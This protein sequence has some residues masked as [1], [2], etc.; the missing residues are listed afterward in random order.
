VLDV[1]LRIAREGAPVPK[2]EAT[3]RLSATA[4]ARPAILVVLLLAGCGG[5]TT[6]TH[7]TGAVSAGQRV[8]PLCPP[9]ARQAMA[10]FL[11]VPASSI[12]PATSTGNNAMPQCTFKASGVAKRPI[13]LIANVD[14]GPQPYFVLERTAVEESQQFTA[15]R[16]IAA[17]QTVSGLGLDAYWFPA[18]T[19]LMT[20]D[21][22]RLITVSVVWHGARQARERALAEA[23]ARPYLR[24][25]KNGSQ[26]KGAP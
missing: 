6:T 1:R 25:Q 20:T 9:V 16:M 21:G 19:R 5:S 18:E 3:R 24:G 14:S 7:S 22:A 13:V 23:L 10:H 4:L 11:A 12:A 2:E 26:A 15:S 8:A 17:P